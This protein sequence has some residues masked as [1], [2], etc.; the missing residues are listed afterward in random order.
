MGDCNSQLPGYSLLPT[1][2]YCK[3]S[4]SSEIV[5]ILPTPLL[6]PLFDNLKSLEEV[7]P[8]SQWEMSTRSY[9]LI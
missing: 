6:R 2:L 9:L 3:E 8:P 1:L 4:D 7:V 5:R